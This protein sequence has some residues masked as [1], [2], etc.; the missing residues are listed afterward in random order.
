MLISYSKKFNVRTLRKLCKIKCIRYVYNF[1]KLKLI[2]ILNEFNAIKIIQD[3]FR[4]KT[5]IDDY[6]P[7]SH[8][9]LKYPFI[10]IKVNNKFFYY[11]FYTL[12]QYLNKSQD[13]REPCTR[14]II[15]D[16]KLLEINKLIRYYYGEKSNKILISKT[17]IKN[18]DLNIIIY[19]LYD[20]VNEVQNKE[21][22]LD[23]IYNNILPRFMYY[24]NYLI[25]NH[26]QEDSQII[27]NACK[28]AVTNSI[29]LDYIR[30]VELINY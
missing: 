14:Q 4:V 13:F 15:T 1:N 30:L 18:T 3:C 2:K 23:D 5:T 17:M 8:E 28:E 21:I 9:K 20:I 10:S 11:D 27:L 12:V 16:N 7:I 22:S 19:C 6:C 24:I 26:T 29:I 25:N